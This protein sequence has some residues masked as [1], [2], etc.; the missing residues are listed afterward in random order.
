M[1]IRAAT[2]AAMV[3][4]KVCQFSEKY[5]YLANLGK[6]CRRH[7]SYF[8]V[9]KYERTFRYFDVTA[10]HVRKVYKENVREDLFEYYLPEWRGRI[11]LVRDRYGR[12]VDLE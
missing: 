4:W 7:E 12:Y 5:G 2:L 1:D 10:D 8:E 3:F 9:G 11:E 6:L